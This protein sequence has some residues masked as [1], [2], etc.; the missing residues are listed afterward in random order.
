MT[1]LES[2]VVHRMLG[3]PLCSPIRRALDPPGLLQVE[4]RS[5]TEVGF[6]TTFVRNTDSKLFDGDIS[7]R[8]GKVGG[9]INSKVDVDFLVYVDDGYLTG[10]EAVTFGGES[11]PSLINEFKLTEQSGINS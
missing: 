11:W 8:W 1:P 10:V 2:A 6:I 9:R 3:D 5:V 4:E 7:M